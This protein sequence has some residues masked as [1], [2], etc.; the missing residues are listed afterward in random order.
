MAGIFFTESVADATQRPDGHVR[1]VGEHFEDWSEA[2]GICK[3][4]NGMDL[5]QDQEAEYWL[6]LGFR[7][8][9]ETPSRAK[10]IRSYVHRSLLRPTYTITSSVRTILQ[11]R[12]SADDTCY[13]NE[14]SRNK[15]RRLGG[16]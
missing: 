11:S 14:I 10:I 5:P 4:S 12:V 15:V 1:M 7:R 6:D 2:L 16:I 13:T 3:E 8:H 9:R